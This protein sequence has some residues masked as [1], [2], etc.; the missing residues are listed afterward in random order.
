MANR[1]S[2]VTTIVVVAGL[3]ASG[4]LLGVTSVGPANAS[5][6]TCTLASSDVTIHYAG[7]QVLGRGFSPGPCDSSD[8]IQT[9]L[10]NNNGLGWSGTFSCHTGSGAGGSLDISSLA[11]TPSCPNG[12]TYYRALSRADFGAWVISST[13]LPC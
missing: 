8:S 5:S 4:V 13:I 3:L 1:R 9:C 2:V 12:T 10:E 11:Y 7:G 6:A